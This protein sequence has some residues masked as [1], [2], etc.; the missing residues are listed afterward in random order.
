MDTILVVD[1]EERICNIY[2]DSLQNQGYKVLTSLNIIEAR[3]ILKGI[4]IDLILLDINT[5]DLKGDV[6]YEI[7][8][9]FHHQI[10]VIISSVYPV[11][12]Q[13][14]IMPEATD[15]FDKSEGIR[16][17]IEKVKKALKKEVI[18]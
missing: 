9:S 1:D 18:S 7:L 17:L 16:V 6:L 3:K 11:E 14:S 4:Q 13:R 10:K 2:R 15:Y 12:E 5:G 8:R